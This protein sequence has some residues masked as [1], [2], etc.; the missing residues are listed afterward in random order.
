[1]FMDMFDPRGMQ[2]PSN[3]SPGENITS[4]CCSRRMTSAVLFIQL[5]VSTHNPIFREGKINLLR[6]KIPSPVQRKTR[7]EADGVACGLSTSG[8]QLSLA[9]KV[10][11]HRKLYCWETTV[12]LF[13]FS[14]MNEKSGD[15]EM[16]SETNTSET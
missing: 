8:L 7:R 12:T 6:G 5:S 2:L 9:D 13:F 15:A 11:S 1:M 4:L 10:L 14:K 16:T 3:L